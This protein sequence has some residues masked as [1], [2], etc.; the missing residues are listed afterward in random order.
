MKSR[1]SHITPLGGQI[2][3]KPQL[4]LFRDWPEK[5]T[6]PHQSLSSC[7]PI[8]KNHYCFWLITKLSKTFYYQFAENTINFDFFPEKFFKMLQ[9]SR[10]SSFNKMMEFDLLGTFI[11]LRYIYI[12]IFPFLRQLK[13]TLANLFWKQSSFND[14]IIMKSKSCKIFTKVSW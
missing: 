3:K 1:K 12:F 6:L 9:V 8:L 5:A 7:P 4:W 11:F 2:P 13:G 10:K 14:F